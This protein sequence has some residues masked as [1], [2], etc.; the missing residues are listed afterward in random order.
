V[1]RKEEV[2]RPSGWSFGQPQLETVS[3]PAPKSVRTVEEW[4]P[5]TSRGVW[6]TGQGGDGTRVA[7]ARGGARVFFPE[8]EADADG[9]E[10]AGRHLPAHVVDGLDDV[11]QGESTGHDAGGEESEVGG[12]EGKALRDG[13]ASRSING[14]NGAELAKDAV[15]LGLG[16][17]VPIGLDE[18]AT[19]VPVVVDRSN[20]RHGDLLG[21]H[22]GD[23]VLGLSVPSPTVRNRR[24]S[25]GYHR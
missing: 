5:W 18:L 10:V 25:P 1:S 9:G 22:I 2:Q 3:V 17:R 7:R 19:G 15:A 23:H 16:L 11:G 4:V 24:R 6:Q 21:D 12:L 20:E 14:L 8:V 13:R